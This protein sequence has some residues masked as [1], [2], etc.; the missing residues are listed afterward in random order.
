MHILA[1]PQPRVKHYLTSA[2]HGEGGGGWPVAAR[3][4]T[5]VRG[6]GGGREKPGSL[7]AFPLLLG[8]RHVVRCDP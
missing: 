1:Q 8:P 2:T 5:H 3:P 7:R 6:E 4:A